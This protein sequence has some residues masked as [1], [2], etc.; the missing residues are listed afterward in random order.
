MTGVVAAAVAGA[1]PIG[2]LGQ[3][4][5]IGTLLAFVI[6]CLGVLLLRYSNPEIPR[7]FRTPMV[8][9]VPI[10]G[11]VSCLAL[12]AGLPKDTWLRLLIWLAIG[13]VIYFVYGKNNSRIGAAEGA[14]PPRMR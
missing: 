14:P 5:S 9:L 13:L 8:P 1:F 11:I 6:V 12:M 7:V 10:L 2:L 3:L 4:V